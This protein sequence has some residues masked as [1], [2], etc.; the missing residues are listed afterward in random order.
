MKAYRRGIADSPLHGGHC[1]PWLFKRMKELGGLITEAIVEFFGPEEFLRR[2]SDPF[3]FQS[4]GCLLGF[5]WHSSGLTTTL[6]GALKEGLRGKENYLGLF[7]CGGKGKVSRQTP[8]EIAHYGEHYALDFAPRLIYCSKL[9]AKV[10]N[11]ALQD[12]YQLYHHVFLFTRSGKWA[13]VQQGMNQ[14]NRLARRY[15]WFGPQV[16]DFG[17]EPHQGICGIK[18][19]KVLNLVAQASTSC[20]Q[21]IV[22][23]AG[24]GPEVIGNELL[25]TKILSLPHRHYLEEGDFNLK[26]VEKTLYQ[27][28][29]FGPTDFESLLAFPGVGPKTVRALALAAEVVLGTPPSFSDPVSFSFAHGGKDGI[30]FPVNR[31]NYDETIE[32]F[33]QV[34]NRSRVQISQ[35]K[36]MYKQLTFLAGC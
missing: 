22:K 4:L 32:F 13:V 34:V 31:E 16:A 26:R 19:K 2:I 30:P 5:D 6:C 21:N 28:A 33:R 20:R 12:G 29:E 14:I 23:L 3:F 11:A 7:V 8:L 18:E 35:K 25:P 9:V 17:C 15:H 10:D 36:E 1:P 27:L 24:E